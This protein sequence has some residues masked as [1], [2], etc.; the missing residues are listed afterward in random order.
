MP[1]C[2]TTGYFAV[3]GVCFDI[4]RVAIFLTCICAQALCVQRLVCPL[5]HMIFR[6]ESSC[7]VGSLALKPPPPSDSEEGLA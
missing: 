4:P 6:W 2:E 5:H 3:P 1:H 7:S